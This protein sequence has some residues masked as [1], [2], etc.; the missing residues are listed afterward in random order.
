MP[1]VDVDAI[2]TA[3]E[4]VVTAMAIQLQAELESLYFENHRDESGR[5]DAL[6]IGRRRIK[7][8]CLSYLSRL[9][10][11]KIQHWSE[12]QFNN[13]R[14]MTDQIAAL[15]NIVHYQHPAK[16]DCLEQFYQQWES[17][18]LVIDKWFAIQAA[19][20]AP[21]T[22]ASVVALT[23]HPAFDMA[24]PNRVRAVIGSFSQANP[25]RFHASSGEGYAFLADQVITLNTLNPQVASRML[26]PLTSWRRFDQTRQNLM[27]TQLERI[28]NSPDISRDVYEV[29]S[30][31][32][33]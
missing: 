25:I 19:S 6:A 4:F 7:N 33:M 14:N 15:A 2:H 26:G 32:L 5:F 21:N 23:G 18:V 16:S 12:Q 29:A 8:T 27:K 22:F 1:I 17:E 28:M 24:N 9:D 13:A 3:R 30:K 20:P 31:S 11:E 10:N